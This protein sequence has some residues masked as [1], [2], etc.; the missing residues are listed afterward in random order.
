MRGLKSRRLNNSGQGTGTRSSV[1]VPDLGAP[2]GP[3]PGT[4]TVPGLWRPVS[5][6]NWIGIG[7]DLG[8]YSDGEASSMPPLDHLTPLVLIIRLQK[9]RGTSRRHQSL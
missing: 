4:P 1:R 9:T 2:R 6:P 7:L 5:I 8:A 3:Q